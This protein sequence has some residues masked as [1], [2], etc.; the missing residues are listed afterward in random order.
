MSIFA[1]TMNRVN[2]VDVIVCYEMILSAR[3][4]QR[5]SRSVGLKAER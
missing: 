3:S 2:R 4:S 5:S 1:D